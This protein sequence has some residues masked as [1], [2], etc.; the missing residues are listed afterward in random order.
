M[1]RSPFA[2]EDFNRNLY[3]PYLDFLTLHCY[4]YNLGIPAAQANWVLDAEIGEIPI[5]HPP[6][7]ES[8][9]TKAGPQTRAAG[10]EPTG[11]PGL[12]RDSGLRFK[13]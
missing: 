13:G 12:N 3:N 5:S 6:E 8:R 11:E 2:G 1:H 10:S 4:P 9:A 7:P